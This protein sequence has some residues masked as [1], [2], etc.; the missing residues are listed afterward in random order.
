MFITAWGRRAA[1]LVAAPG[2]A[3]GL[4]FASLSALTPLT[5]RAQE[6]PNEFSIEGGR[7]D[8]GIDVVG[9]R[10]GRTYGIWEFAGCRTFSE[11]DAEYWHARESQQHAPGS[12]ET[13]GAMG[14]CRF[15]D[16]SRFSPELGFGVRLLSH[17]QIVDDKEYS[18]AF[19]FQEMLG[20]RAKLTDDGRYF[21]D[22]RAR[23]ISN[24]SIKRPNA[25]I[26]T[27]LLSVGMDF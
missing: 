18:T 16:A 15:F 13:I 7:A 3:L 4:T 17:V 6:A 8:D 9:A 12:L 23:H 22:F 20:V 26:N 2:L 10:I 27:L 25:G 24:G 11:A 5:V 1:R 19:Q 21:A 14:G